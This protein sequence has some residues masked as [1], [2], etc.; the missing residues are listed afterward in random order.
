MCE[1]IVLSEKMKS[2]LIKRINT[3]IF[4][5]VI[6]AGLSV[7]LIFLFAW[8]MYALQFPL[9]TAEYFSLLAL[10]SGAM[11]SGFISGRIKRRSG[12]KTGFRCGVILLFLCAVGAA[13]SGN[14]DGTDA[15]A[16]IFTTVICGC[17]GGVIGV[18]RQN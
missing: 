5:T 4:S 3:Y 14:F 16:K 18:N 15:A 6:G 7:V 10:G 12:L 13:I 1:V 8:V 2:E 17:A 11:L 9:Y